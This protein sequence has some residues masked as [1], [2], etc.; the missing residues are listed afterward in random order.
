MVCGVEVVDAR[1]GCAFAEVWTD[2]A[3]AG[4][5]F[6]LGVHVL[7]RFAHDALQF[8]G[9]DSACAWLAFCAVEVEFFL[10]RPA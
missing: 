6:F 10:A 1:T 4:L 5:T 3:H 8:V 7:A 9:G 2:V